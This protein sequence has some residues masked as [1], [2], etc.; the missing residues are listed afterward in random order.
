LGSRVRWACQ[1]LLFPGVLPLPVDKPVPMPPA[2]AVG[3]ADVPFPLGPYRPELEVQAFL[4][5]ARPSLNTFGTGWVAPG[6]PWS[7][8][9][10][11]GLSTP[12]G[13]PGAVPRSGLQLPKKMR[14][15]TVVATLTW[16]GNPRW[17]GGRH[18]VPV[19][20]TAPRPSVPVCGG[21]GPATG[22]PPLTFL[23]SMRLRPHCVQSPGRPDS[24][25][26]LPGDQEV[27]VLLRRGGP[28]RTRPP[29]GQPF[30]P[31]R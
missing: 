10:M 5:P 29:V 28:S 31:P 4:L 17:A 26:P 6:W 8:S 11:A 20:G 15:P 12:A 22:C 3:I 19:A 7:R 2:A 13:R 1:A 24:H 25:P 14:E 21:P 16:R 9:S 23:G 18:L 30:A 27:H